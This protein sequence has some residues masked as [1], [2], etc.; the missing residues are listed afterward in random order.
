MEIIDPGINYLQGEVM[1][2]S[3]TG[4]GFRGITSV[5]QHGEIRQFVFCVFSLCS[6]SCGIL[7]LT[8]HGHRNISIFDHE[9][10]AAYVS[11]QVKL[12]IVYAGTS[13]SQV[14]LGRRQLACRSLAVY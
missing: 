5:N 13:H 6:D 2:K 1:A 9:H 11:G 10:G 12:D 4:V 3:S 8:S 14:L 7:T